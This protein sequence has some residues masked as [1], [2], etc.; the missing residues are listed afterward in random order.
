MWLL[1]VNL[2]TALTGLLRK[3]DVSAETAVERGWRD[4]TNGALAEAASRAGFLVVLTR[5]RRFGAS[6]Q[7]VLAASPR[8]AV[9]IVTLSQAREAA[10]LTEFEAAWGRTPIEPVAGAIIEWP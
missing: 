7:S 8:L 4:L 2:P 9:V 10:Y 6:V 5:D 3:H 1:D